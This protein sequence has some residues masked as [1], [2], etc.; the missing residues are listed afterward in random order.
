MHKHTRTHTHT[1]TRTLATRLVWGRIW[2][3]LSQ[4][5]AAV[6][7]HTNLAVAMYAVD[8]LRQVCVCVCWFVRACVRVCV[9]VCVYLCVFVRACV[10]TF[11]KATQHSTTQRNTTQRNTTQH[12]A[13]HTHLPHA[14]QLAMK[15]LEKDELS[16]YT[17]QNDFMRPFVSVMRQS[18]VR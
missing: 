8:S 11:H 6:G 17:F 1:H 4:Y 10:R 12:N 14:P 2:A 15:F 9:R 3:V 13:T 16:N 5:F 7:C 18:Q